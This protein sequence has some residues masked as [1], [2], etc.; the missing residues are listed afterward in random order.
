MPDIIN[1]ELAGLTVHIQGE[2]V[3]FDKDGKGTIEKEQAYRAALD[4]HNFHPAPE[5]AKTKE[6]ED[7][8]P[9]DK[10]PKDE[11][12]KPVDEK[13]DGEEKKDAE[14]QKEAPKAT[15]TKKPATAKK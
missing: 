15:A 1:T 12:K 3:T 14:E 13:V 6:P 8:E 11:D 10:E 4:L 9:E 7:K 5:P 2:Q